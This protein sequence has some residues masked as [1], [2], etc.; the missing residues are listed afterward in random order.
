MPDTEN[1]GLGHN[2]GLNWQ[3]AIEQLKEATAATRTKLDAIMVDKKLENGTLSVR[4]FYD[5]KR[6]EITDEVQAQK[7]SQLLKDIRSYRTQVA[8][9]AKA[10][11]KPID[12]ALAMFK[13]VLALWLDPVDTFGASVRAK[14][15]AYQ[16]KK[17]ARETAERQTQA[18]EAERLRKQATPEAIAQAEVVEKS[19][20]A[21][22]ATRT[23]GD[24]GSVASSKMAWDFRILKPEL[25]R[26]E[27]CQPDSVL[28]RARMKALDSEL[29]EKLKKLQATP[30][31]PSGS[32]IIIN[33][34]EPGIEFFQKVASR[35][36]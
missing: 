30:G 9:I 7:A 35:I 27:L 8:E 1:P 3:V 36:A 22:V 4:E 15:D 28:V 24:H 34:L 31:L 6:P 13:N 19:A 12:D 18:A 16:A 11:R 10:E 21:P 5:T 25:V 23:R 2:S 17:L 32:S 33:D 20:A 14:F 26:R 29:D